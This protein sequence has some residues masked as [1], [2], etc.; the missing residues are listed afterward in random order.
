MEPAPAARV[1]LGLG[2]NIGDRV[3]QLRRGLRSLAPDVTIEAVSPLYETEPVG[4][5]DQPPFLNA[6]CS[7]WTALDP[8]ALLSRL[9]SIEYEV[10]RRPGPRWGPRPLDL[11]I[12]VYGNEVV[13][14]PDLQIPHQRMAERAFVLCPFADL[15][16]D[17]HVP[18]LG[19]TVRELL[20]QVSA[21]GVRKVAERDWE[22][23]AERA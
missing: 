23:E 3:G 14:A 20:G 21:E 9:K 8:H 13:A 4:V 7:A 11:D 18:G 5:A 22:Q 10:G 12:L 2:A 6:V 15:A 1:Y 19:R 16:P 17:L